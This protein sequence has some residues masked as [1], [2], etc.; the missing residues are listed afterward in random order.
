MAD[1]TGVDVYC[2]M[3]NEER[4]V[5]YFLRHYETIADRIFV[6]DDDSTDQTVKLLSKH[7]KVIF[8]KKDKKGLD[9][10]YFVND[11]FPKYEQISR[12]TADWVIVVDA[13]EY[14]YHPDLLRVL[15]DS[16]EV[17][18]EAIQCKGYAM[19]SDHFP[20]TNGQIYD[21]V[22]MG[23]DDW[24]E[25]KWVIHSTTAKVRYKKGRHGQIVNETSVKRSRYKYTGVKLLHYRYLGEDWIESRDQKNTFG[26]NVAYPKLNAIHNRHTPRHCPDRTKRPILEWFAQNKDRVFNVL[27]D[28]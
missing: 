4:L 6:W 25:S 24:L 10:E 21:E 11:L 16:K 14:V 5:P 22:F 20:T 13:D 19:I 17:G 8:L 23:V 28:V 26:N 1:K 7:P 15:A 3:Y 9:D 18:V 12:G 2:P 27:E